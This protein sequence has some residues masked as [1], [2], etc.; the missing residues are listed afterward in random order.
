MLKKR[1]FKKPTGP[2][3]I[4]TLVEQYDSAARD[5]AWRWQGRDFD[6][7][8]ETIPLLEE[9]LGQLHDELH[10]KSFKQRLGLG[11]NES[12]IAQWANLWGIYLGEALRVQRGGKWI[13][14]HSEGP[15]LLA[16]EFPDGTVIFPTARVFRRLSDGAAENVEEYYQMVM[17]E[18]ESG[19]GASEEEGA[20]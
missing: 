5:A 17:R 7:S 19:D 16:V 18:V 20:G 2:V 9:M 13:T 10:Q 12:D 3:P 14:G 1:A 15:N 8:P 6:H 11:N 4:E